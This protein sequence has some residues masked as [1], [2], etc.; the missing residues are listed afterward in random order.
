M[1]FT[2]VSPYAGPAGGIRVI[3]EYA[4][5]LQRRGHDVVVVSQPRRVQW[6]REAGK[7]ILYREGVLAEGLNRFSY[8]DGRSFEHRVINEVRPVVPDDVPDADVVVATWWE[9]AEWVSQFPA[10]KGSQ[11]YL[12]QH[13]EVWFDQPE[14]R[15]HA[16]W[17]LPMQLIVVSRWLEGRIRE[18]APD[19]DVTVIP[20][21]VDFKLFR[22]GSRSK[23]S[24]PTIGTLYAPA[25]SKGFDLAREAIERVRERVPELRVVCFGVRGESKRCPLPAGTKL[26]TRPDQ[27]SIPAIYAS[28]DAWICASR[29]E[30]FGLPPLEA[31]ACGTPAVSSRVGGMPDLIHPGSNGYLCDVGDTNEMARCLIEALSM[32]GADWAALSR[33]A[34]AS[35]RSHTWDDAAEMFEAAL[36]RALYGAGRSGAVVM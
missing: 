18:Y 9:T 21:S 32:D 17:Q 10:R 36:L 7:Y 16:T 27:S 3:A 23:Q 25:H 2:F 15:V 14:S 4:E 35:A 1:K 19:A 8:Y 26:H 33:A 34:V 20:N 11:A 29:A 28:C 6:L 30:G 12:I 31:M 13:D 22:W 5:R 24:V